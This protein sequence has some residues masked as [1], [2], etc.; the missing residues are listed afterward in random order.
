MGWRVDDPIL[1]IAPESTVRVNFWFRDRRDAGAQWAMGHPLARPA[2]LITERVSKEAVCEIG[3]LIQTDPPQYICQDTGPQ[4]WLYHA[5]I[6]NEGSQGCS[7]KIE[8][9][10]V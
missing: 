1:F 2:T 7:F 9:G 8:G 10:G 5:Y 3:R 4:Y 6:T